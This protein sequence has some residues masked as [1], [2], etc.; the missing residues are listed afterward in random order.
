MNNERNFLIHP[1]MLAL[2]LLLMG[3]SALFIGFSFAYLYTRVQSGLE[4]I[5]LPIL[6]IINSV[7]LLL[8]S[9]TL[10]RAMR[11]YKSD[12]T[13]AYKQNLLF[14]LI[15]TS[16]FL[17]SQIMAWKQLYSSGIL[18]NHGNMASYLYM[19]SGIHFAHVIIGI[20]FLAWFYYKAIKDMVEPV[21]V[22]IYF[23]DPTRRRKLK[24]L[25]IYWHFLDGLWVYLV[26]FFLINQLI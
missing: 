11:F 17:V 25:T 20:P 23:S 3:V 13:V 14:T 6:F 24:L 10:V 18:I 19:I 4:P 22:L 1:H 16:L 15:L 2:V 21:S 26:L 5:N 12:N 9:W 8:S 7:M